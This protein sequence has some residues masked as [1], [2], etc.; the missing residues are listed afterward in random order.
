MVMARSSDFETYAGK[1]DLPE[2]PLSCPSSLA[3]FSPRN[4]LSNLLHAKRYG[5][6]MYG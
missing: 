1:D 5:R 3:P 2:F 6:Q 4:G